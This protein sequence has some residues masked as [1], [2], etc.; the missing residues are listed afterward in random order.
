[1]NRVWWTFRQRYSTIVC[2][3]GSLPREY[4]LFMRF[5]LRRSRRP[6]CGDS[7]S[8]FNF[9]HFNST[10]YLFTVCL[11]RGSIAFAI[12]RVCSECWM[13]GKCS[14]LRISLSWIFGATIRKHSKLENK[15]CNCVSAFQFISCIITCW[16]I[17]G[18]DALI[19]SSMWW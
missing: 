3:L 12:I 10:P 4:W 1:M 13:R 6:R 9:D 18:F 16:F 2:S 11:H 17:G 5:V 15:N 19:N 7:K 14:R 8:E